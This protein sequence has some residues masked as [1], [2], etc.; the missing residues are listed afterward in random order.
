VIEEASGVID[1][2]G[3]RAYDAVQLGGCLALRATLRDE[4]EIHFVCADHQLLAAA[5]SEGIPTI[6]PK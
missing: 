6:E 5:H 3:L 1:R 4:M 2:H